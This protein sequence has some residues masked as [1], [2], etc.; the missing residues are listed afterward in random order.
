MSIQDLIN[1]DLPANAITILEY[2]AINSG[3]NQRDLAD[4]LNLTKRQV[5]YAIKSLRENELIREIPDINEDG[6]ADFRS[7]LISLSSIVESALQQ[8]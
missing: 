6:H 1:L 4:A 3:I 8:N 7:K 5:T 2:L